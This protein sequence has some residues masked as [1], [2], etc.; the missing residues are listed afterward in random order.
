M[1]L[2]LNIDNVN[3]IKIVYKD[4]NDYAHCIKASLKRMDERE[5]LACAKFEES[6]FIDVPQ[7]VMISIACDNGLYKAVT[8]LKYIEKEEPY[9][10]FT[11]SLPDDIE[12]QQKREYFRVK[13]NENALIS[14]EVE[15][16]K[17]KSISCET[18]DLSANGVRL[19]LDVRYDIPSIVNIKLYLPKKTI[20]VDAKYIRTDEEDNILKAS[21]SFVDLKDSDLDCISQIC[22]QKQLEA[23]R[24]SLM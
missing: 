4:K 19:M 23:R 1:K 3:Y 21:F 5:I 24:K 10:F 6:L 13:I 18:Y 22:F 2:N 12:Y 17:A 20:D 15:D 8:Q 14:Y 16:G 11:M 9:I 7:N